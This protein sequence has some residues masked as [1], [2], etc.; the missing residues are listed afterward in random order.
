MG[1]T[2]LQGIIGVN[3]SR[4]TASA[5]VV[6]TESRGSE[7]G[8]WEPR[9]N[10]DLASSQATGNG[11][12]NVGLTNDGDM[13]RDLTPFAPITSPR[14]AQ[15]CPTHGPVQCITPIITRRFLSEIRWRIGNI[16]A[17]MYIILNAQH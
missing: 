10:L 2:M 5:M 14:P 15:T 7:S 16:L 4:A 17:L 13:P 11:A 12:E 1:C 6:G 9:D 3:V 8:A